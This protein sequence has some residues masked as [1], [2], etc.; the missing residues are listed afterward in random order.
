M[1]FDR[2]F[3]EGN[4]LDYSGRISLNVNGI[5]NPLYETQ[6]QN[7][8]VKSFDGFNVKVI[9]SSYPNLDPISFTY[10]YPGEI[11]TVNKGNEIIARSGTQTFDIPV[12]VL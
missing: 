10:S 8:Q 7:F 1:T 6:T 2:V 9:E 12:T 11:V 3:L 5:L 4:S